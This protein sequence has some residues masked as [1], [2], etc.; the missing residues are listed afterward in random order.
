MGYFPK[1]S[2]IFWNSIIEIK[3]AFS[4]LFPRGDDRLLFAKPVAN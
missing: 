3:K 4:V 2:N 1:Y